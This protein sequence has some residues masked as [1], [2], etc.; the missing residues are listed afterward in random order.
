MVRAQLAPDRKVVA[1]GTPGWITVVVDN[2]DRRSRAIRLQ[3]G[4]AMSR[5]SRPRLSTI[6]VLPGEQREVP[7]EVAPLTTAPEGGHDYELTLTATDMT[8]GSFLDR[9]SARLAVEARPALKGKPVRR[10]KAVDNVP[11]TLQL[12]IYNSGNV[13]LRVEV[14]AVDTY[15]WVR[16][17]EGQR[18]RDRIRS[19]RSGIGT[20][21]SD[22]IA[23]EQVR[24]GHNWTIEIDAMAPRYR[25]GF[26][27][28]RWLIP[29]G[30]QAQGW[31]PECVFLELDQQPRT[32]LPVRAAAFGAAVLVALVVL[33]AFMLWLAF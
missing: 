21:V 30:V 14:F 15:W 8:D 32:L 19:V 20:I 4:G 16:E 2:H 12:V 5:Y 33:V 29:I 24:P 10:H 23:A 27:A 13:P 22:P 7:V 26:A 11:V 9:S 28:R 31:S 17:G 18:A 3:L 25:I 6:D 1:P